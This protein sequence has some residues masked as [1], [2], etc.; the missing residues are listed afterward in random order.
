MN[1][2]L[3]VVKWMIFKAFADLMCVWNMFCVVS[4]KYWLLNHVANVIVAIGSKEIRN[5][6]LVALFLLEIWKSWRG[7][8][9]DLLLLF[10]SSKRIRF[11][12]VPVCGRHNN[13][14]FP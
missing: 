7:T 6:L 8:L 10:D 13:N 2:L 1:M 3:L 5:V 12:Y 9:I 4:R 14:T 11:N